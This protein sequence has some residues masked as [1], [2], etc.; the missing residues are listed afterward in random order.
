MSAAPDVFTLV[1]DVLPPS[2]HV[3]TFTGVEAISRLYSIEVLFFMPESDAAD[4]DLEAALLKRASLQINR[5][6]GTA[7]NTLN[8]VISAIELVSEFAGDSIFRAVLVPQ[9]W[10]MTLG[11]SSRVFAQ[12]GTPNTVP[13]IIEKGLKVHGFGAD[14]YALRLKRNYPP[15]LHIGQYKESDF[16]FMSRLM[17]REGIYY[18]FEQG[19]TSEKLIITDAI[20]FQEP[21][22]DT[23]VRY[24]PVGSDDASQV[25]A[26]ETFRAR[27]AAVSQ[28]VWSYDYDYNQPVDVS[29]ETEVAA[30]GSGKVFN[31][32]ENVASDG[33]AERVAEL[34]ADEMRSRQKVFHGRGRLFD[35][36]SGYHFTL[37]EHPKDALNAKY[38]C[39]EVEHF[40]N[41]LAAF[42]GLRRAVRADDDRTYKVAVTAIPAEVQFRPAR[43]TAVPR[44]HGVEAG[45]V[46]GPA[47]SE[48]AQIDEQGRYKVHLYFDSKTWH[49]AKASTWLRMIQP[50]GGN[51]EGFHFPL[52]KGTEVTI[53]FVG[54]DPDRP[55]ISGVAPN[56]DTPSVV[57]SANHTQ[58]VVHTGGNSRIEIEDTDG[59][60][61]VDIS[62]PPEKTFI[63]LGATHG[64]HDHNWIIK[65]DGTGLVHTG[66]NEDVFVGGK[67]TEH[68]VGD[69]EENYDSNQKTT[70]LGDKERTVL[71]NETTTVVSNHKETVVGSQTILV[72][73][74][75][76]LTVLGGRKVTVLGGQDH[77]IVGAMKLLL[78]GAQTNLIASTQTTLVGSSQTTVVAS[79]QTNMIV[80]SQTNMIVGAQTSIILG[81]GTVIAP[82]GY[83]II[84]P[85]GYTVVAPSKWYKLAV[86]SGEAIAIK[87]SAFGV[88]TDVGGMSIAVTGA[89]VDMYA[90]KADCGPFKAS[91]IGVAIK[92]HAASIKTTAANLYTAAVNLFT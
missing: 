23:P 73:S 29:G 35:V 7:R 10:K 49:P 44:I 76:K 87:L 47:D 71:G 39:V 54:G 86:L 37:D 43:R 62:T 42:P 59:A 5:D 70:V 3:L 32:G 11:R 84:A 6:D 50:H 41:Q 66:G 1:S 89:K 13:T 79:S 91:T 69:V 36:R 25:E 14:D 26:M 60:Q 48:Y 2:T 4:L 31:W 81:G 16:D 45:V 30:N 53:I 88:K 80:G 68:V 63:H 8:G 83:T 57:T 92:T 40:G 15:Q 22:V 9:M 33:A 64:A 46:D 55:M 75:Q 77:M 17:E 19:E 56:P 58:N 82:P 38:L 85:G 20:S 51:P 61:Y 18:Y 27:H 65:T 72:L 67:L 24:F 21:F 90:T 12:E 34:R 78:A 74:G 28:E 52:R